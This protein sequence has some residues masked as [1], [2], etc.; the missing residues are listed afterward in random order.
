MLMAPL[1][2]VKDAFPAPAEES[3]GNGA[4]FNRNA[5]AKQQNLERTTILIAFRLV[6][7][8]VAAAGVI[9]GQ[10][11]ACGVAG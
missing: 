3:T 5:E 4:D 8:D 2:Q 1:P 7:L 9:V 11:A 6:Q 10:I